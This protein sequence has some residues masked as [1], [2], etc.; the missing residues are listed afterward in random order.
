MMI[1]AV[2]QLV[3]GHSEGD[4]YAILRLIGRGCAVGF[5]RRLGRPE[6]L[7]LARMAGGSPCA[8]AMGKIAEALLVSQAQA[9][10]APIS[11]DY[12]SACNKQAS[13]QP[14]ER[15]VLFSVEGLEAH[16]AIL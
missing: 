2:G 15:R 8:G 5:Q 16:S 4:Y 13:S 3:N 11:W 7:P 6:E 1:N 9:E 12:G 10:R 14:P